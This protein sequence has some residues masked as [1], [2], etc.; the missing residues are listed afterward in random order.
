[1]MEQF[2]EHSPTFMVAKL[3]Q[4]AL[5]LVLEKNHDYY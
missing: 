2:S 5:D 3:H 4:E 1:M